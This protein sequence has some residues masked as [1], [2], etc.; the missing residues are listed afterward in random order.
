MR[1][2]L[3]S[4][5]FII[6]SFFVL[7]LFFLLTVSGP[8]EEKAKPVVIPEC[9]QGTNTTCIL[10]TCMGY[11]V[12]ESGEWSECKMNRI[13]IPGEI[14]PCIENYCA[15]GYKTCNECGTGYSECQN[16]T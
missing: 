6:I 7:V 16:L 5:F 9:S 2:N 11:R 12:C 15:K 8:S 13:C 10:G 1:H 4:L 3:D 14:K